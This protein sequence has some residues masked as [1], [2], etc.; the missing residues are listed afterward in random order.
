VNLLLLL[1]HWQLSFKQ[2]FFNTHSLL[3][4]LAVK[5]KQAFSLH[6]Y[7]R[8]FIAKYQRTIILFTLGVLLIVPISACA[9][10]T[11]RI[12]VPSAAHSPTQERTIDHA[13]GQVS[14]PL[15]PQ[16]I[17]A[18]GNPALDALLAL[19]MKP[20]G[21]ATWGGVNS[22]NGVQHLFLNGGMEEI[23][24]LGQDT[25]P[26]LEKLLALKPDLILGSDSSNE[27]IYNRLSQI[28]PTVL[29]RWSGQW[30]PDTWKEDFKLYAEALGK[31]DAAKQV[32]QDYNQRI[33]D[34]KKQMGNR[35]SRTHVSVLHFEP[36][37]VRLYMKASYIG[38]VLQDCGLPRPAAQDRNEWSELI[39]LEQI[40]DVDGDVIFVTEIDPQKTSYQ[41]FIN[42]PLWQQL[43]AVQS[44]QVY[45]VNYRYWIGGSGP[46]S[47]K[48]I[49]DD[50]FHHLTNNKK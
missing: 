25:Q 34:F 29:T 43:K 37:Q 35:L 16:R 48:L 5:M 33:A 13:L 28:A 49:L 2:A 40:S 50:L 11:N 10:Q 30:T 22:L 27:K 31:S 24:Y 15:H 7:L 9:K 46:V 39:S 21:V 44:N 38:G 32:L 20:V 8:A 3:M 26:N 36:G 12:T 47:T 41:E 6:Q 19:D 42:N 23:E 1:A 14:V 17:V 4:R 45:E 18:L